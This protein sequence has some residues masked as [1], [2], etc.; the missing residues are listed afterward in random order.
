MSPSEAI[1]AT[2]PPVSEVKDQ[3]G[4]SLTLRRL[5]AIDR[6]R[7]FKALGPVLSENA[8]YLGMA[9]LAVSVTSI[10]GV[11]LPAPGSEAQVEALILRLGD[12]GLEAA[13]SMFPEAETSSEQQANYAGN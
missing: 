10:D 5:N 4:R 13:A 12:E 11:P 8:A 9:L 1:A 6:L 2:N 7:L 3:L